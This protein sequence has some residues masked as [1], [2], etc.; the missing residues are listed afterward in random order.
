MTGD[1][2]AI[3]E[4]DG[5]EHAI[6]V[7]GNGRLVLEGHDRANMQAIRAAEGLGATTPRCVQVLDAWRRYQIRQD[8]LQW[9]PLELQLLRQNV[10][11][12]WRHRADRRR[13]AGPPEN[14]HWHKSAL[15]PRIGSAVRGAVKRLFEEHLGHSD[16]RTTCQYTYDLTSARVD[17]QVMADQPHEQWYDIYVAADWMRSVYKK[18]LTH[19]DGAVVLAARENGNNTQTIRAAHRCQDGRIV[20]RDG[21]V[22]YWSVLPSVT[23]KAEMAPREH[24]DRI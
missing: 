7:R 8:M 1:V 11:E 5:S 4:C 10:H 19:I 17:W 18:R 20:V 15:G 16:P 22:S 21:I 3:V 9:C 14:V 6:V 12:I 24:W 23:W 2:R 13:T